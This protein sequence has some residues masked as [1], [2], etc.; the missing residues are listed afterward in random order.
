MRPTSPLPRSAAVLPFEAIEPRESLPARPVSRPQFPLYVEPAAGEALL[1]WLLRLATRLGVSF[2]TLSAAGFGIDD[3][4]VAPQWSRRPHP[5][6]LMRISQ[7][8]GLS[9]A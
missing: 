4:A 5:W 1:S 2:R 7:R 3:Y 8:T 9:V 6:L